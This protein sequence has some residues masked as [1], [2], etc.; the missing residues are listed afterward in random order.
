MRVP[1]AD[2]TRGGWGL[3]SVPCSMGL[4]ELAAGGSPRD[5]LAVVHRGWHSSIADLGQRPLRADQGVL[6]NRNP[7]ELFALLRCSVNAR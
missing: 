5:N 6:P 7:S 1:D 3:P 4:R 2:L